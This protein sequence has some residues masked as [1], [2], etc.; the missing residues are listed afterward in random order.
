MKAFTTRI[1]LLLLPWLLFAGHGC[2][3]Y[4][5]GPEYSLWPVRQRV[6]NTWTWSYALE[7]GENNTGARADSTLE[8]AADQTVRI[9]AKGSD[10]CRTGT[11]NLVRKQT[12]LQMI[13]DGRAVAYDIQRLLRQEMWLSVEDNG[14]TYDWEL[15]PAE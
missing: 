2:V 8:L 11:W 7:N 12:K 3:E 14:V 6:L 9:C 13:F 10:A 5:E 1:P 15:V 4:P